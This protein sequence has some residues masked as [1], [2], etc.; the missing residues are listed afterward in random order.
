MEALL[1]VLDVAAAVLLA[2][3]AARNDGKPAISGLFRYRGR[4]DA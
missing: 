1:F 2:V 3:W 4:P